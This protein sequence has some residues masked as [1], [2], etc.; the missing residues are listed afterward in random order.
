VSVRRVHVWSGPRNVST[1]LMYSFAQRADTTALDEPLYAHHLARTGLPHPGRDDV[2]A[3]QD[4]DGARVVREVL[5][6]PCATP[7]LFAKQMAHHAE[8]LDWGFLD[9][10]VSALLVRHPR[11]MLPSLAKVTPSPSLD[12]TGLPTQARLFAHL[13]ARGQD[14]AVVDARLLL[15]DPPGVLERLCARLGLAFDEAMLS[16]PA[17]PKDC[18]GVWAPHW[19]AG[20]HRSTGFQPYRP[21]AEPVPDALLPLLD[22]CLPLYDDLRREAERTCLS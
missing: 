13:R 12:D 3:A 2:L 8:G 11:E 16:W 14:P 4:R 18:D 5:L 20:V 7:V 22:E 9:A 6:G 10:G 19:Y 1:A 21:K 15:E 17:G